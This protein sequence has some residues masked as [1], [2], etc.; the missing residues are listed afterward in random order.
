MAAHCYAEREGAGPL[1]QSGMDVFTVW[2]VF[3]ENRCLAGN[4]KRGS[5]SFRFKRAQ[6]AVSSKSYFI[7][8]KT[9]KVGTAVQIDRTMSTLPRKDTRR[10]CLPRQF[11]RDR[12]LLRVPSA[13]FTEKLRPRS[14][15]QTP[16]L[17]PRDLRQPSA[18]RR[19]AQAA[20]PP[21][22]VYA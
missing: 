16:D 11:S 18:W 13:P 2:P 21:M 14:R 9:F 19:V 7:S 1:T 8:S 3:T 4:F 20:S 10:D 6:N 22:A 5:A 12:T 17:R 15:V